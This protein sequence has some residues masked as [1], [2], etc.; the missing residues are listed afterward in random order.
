MT[1]RNSS[2]Q[3]GSAVALTTATPAN[4]S[5]TSLEAG[6]WLVWGALDA[7]LTGATITA[8]AASLSLVSGALSAQPGASVAPGRLYPEPLA[9]RVLNLV[10]ANGTES[11]PV[12]P[13]IMTVISVP[14]NQTMTLYLVGQASFSAGSVSACGSLFAV[15]LP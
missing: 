8:L 6:T 9:Q 12:G 13:T 15:A 11:L 10:T 14:Q 4:I 3:A 1:L 5:S 7:I 2:T